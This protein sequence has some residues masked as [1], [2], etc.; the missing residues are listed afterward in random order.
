MSR[1]SSTLI[2]GILIERG[3]CETVVDAAILWMRTFAMGR[4]FEEGG[5]GSVW[6]VG[7]TQGLSIR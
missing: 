6:S 2:G 5:E 1:V 7:R 3:F 4:S